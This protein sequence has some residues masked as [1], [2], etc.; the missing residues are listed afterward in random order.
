MV[1]I[2][3]IILTWINRLLYLFGVLLFLSCIT[4]YKCE[5]PNGVPYDEHIDYNFEYYLVA[6]VCNIGIYIFAAIERKNMWLR[7]ILL[8][9]ATIL[10]IGGFIYRFV[11]PC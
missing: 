2:L 3:F 1:R 6:F 8:I 9:F 11:I 10:L 7:H 4:S 5:A